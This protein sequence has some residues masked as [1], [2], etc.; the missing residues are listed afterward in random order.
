[1]H[2]I[3]VNEI[4][5][6]DNEY[7]YA[8]NEKCVQAML[9]KWESRLGGAAELMPTHCISKTESGRIE[10]TA[11]AVLQNSTLVYKMKTGSTFFKLLIYITKSKS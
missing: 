11:Q 1:V 8:V 3:A 5:H 7:I 2:I 6:L 4:V 9:P 10:P